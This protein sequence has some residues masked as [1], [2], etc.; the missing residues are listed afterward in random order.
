[1]MK[2]LCI[3]L[4][5]SS[6]LIAAPSANSAQDGAGGTRSIFSVGAGSRAIA[7]GGAFSALCDD[8]SAIYYNPAGLRLNSYPGIMVNHI[9]LFSGFSDATYDYVG[10]VYPTLSVGSIGLGF[11]TAGTG[12]IRGFDEFSR[13]TGE[14]SYRESQAMLAYGFNLP[15][16]L[17][18]RYT[19]G[20]TAKVL[21]QRIGDFSDTGAGFDVGILYAP[22]VLEGLVLGCNLQ[23]IVGAETKLVSESEKVDRTLMIGAGY[24]RSFENGSALAVGVQFD[25]P[26]RADNDFR[27]GA[28]YSYKRIMSIRVGFDSEMITA[29]IGVSWRGYTVDYGFFSRDEAGSSHPISLSARFGSSTADKIRHREERRAVEEERRIQEIF[30]NRLTAHLRAAEEHRAAGELEQAIDELKIALDYDPGN[31]AAAETLDVV[32]GEILARER[33]RT[34][35]AEKALLIDQHFNL[36]LRYYSDSEYT[37]ARAEWLNVLELDPESE[38]ARDYLQRTEEKLAERVREH[39]GRALEFERSGQ[40]A[41]AIAEWNIVRMIDPESSEAQDAIRRV[42]ERMEALSRNYRDAR[43]RLETID[44]FENALKAF[45]EGRYAETISLCERLLGREPDHNEARDLMRRAMRRMTP[46]TAEEK[47]EIR[48]LYIQGMKYFTQSNYA[49]AIGEW[50]KVLEID[51]DNESVRKNIEE[52]KARLQKIDAS[53][54]D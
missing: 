19:L 51:P 53:E 44:L 39:R 38:Q 4:L 33:E 2:R 21:N 1:M 30:S 31:T 47:E 8:P 14:I 23:D 24:R 7:M 54:G 18:G 20:A 25:M 10:L 26:E 22:P 5:V 17:F 46:L 42:E 36:G 34:R 3:Y 45:G 27:V 41:A 52:A 49:A 48:R 9:Q 40:H 29:G 15:W 35:S 6:L 16:R 43:D 12:S 32:R 28:E 11:V 50:Q 37:L 13:E